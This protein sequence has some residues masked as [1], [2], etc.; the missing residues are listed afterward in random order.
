[1]TRHITKHRDDSVF[2][3]N[4]NVEWVEYDFTCGEVVVSGDSKTIE[5][6][7]GKF[8]A[9]PTFPDLFDRIDLLDLTVLTELSDSPPSDS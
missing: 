4:R 7:S 2:Y 3:D 8:V 1:M 6:A 5:S 9:E